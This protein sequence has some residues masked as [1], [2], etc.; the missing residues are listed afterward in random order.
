MTSVPPPPGPADPDQPTQPDHTP[1]LFAPPGAQAAAPQHPAPP[2]GQYGQYGQVGPYAQPW[3]AP[4]QWQHAQPR[5]GDPYPQQGQYAPP[6]QQSQYA[7]PAQL[8]TPGQL[9]GQPSQPAQHSPWA[10]PPPVTT[11]RS[12]TPVVLSVIG[13]VVVIA[14]AVTAAILLSG[15][16]IET[17]P[18]DVD[19]ATQ[20]HA[21]E[22]TVGNCLDSVPDAGEVAA[23]TVVPCSDTHDAQV[24]AEK[25][26]SG[27]RFPGDA[28]VI[29]QTTAVCPGRSITVDA[30][31]ED[32]EL[33]VWTP[34]SASW[35]E[36]DRQGVCI[37][38]SPSTP[39]T[40]SLIR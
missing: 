38:S 16:D 30:V 29:A 24:I 5:P 1:P 34:S 19:S 21:R 14:L 39:L 26:F 35:D 22:L 27:E 17:L 13:G 9:P 36:G 11:K 12:K 37:A 20:A 23:V 7:P 8:P 15:P 25:T 4:Q 31:P 18:E 2:P 28:R 3:G 40:G 32:L 6:G 33:L 10:A